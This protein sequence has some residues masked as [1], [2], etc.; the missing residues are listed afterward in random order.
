MPPQRRIVGAG[1]KAQP[2]ASSVC[3]VERNSRGNVGYVSRVTGQ[4]TSKHTSPARPSSRFL[5]D[6]ITT[7]FPVM[8]RSIKRYVDSPKEDENG[9]RCPITHTRFVDWTR[10][11]ITKSN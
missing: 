5:R 11:S 1:A 9:H 4:A 2:R 8:E 6:H 7:R 10:S 3:P